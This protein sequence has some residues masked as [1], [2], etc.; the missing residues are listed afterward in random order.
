MRHGKR[1]KLTTS[2]I[3]NALKL[4]NV[5]VNGKLHSRTKMTMV[6]LSWQADLSNICVLCDSSPCMGFSRKSLSLFA[7]QAV[8]EESSIFMRKRKS[9]SVIL[10]T[11]RFPEF[12]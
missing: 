3:D 9:T 5:E 7:L 2:D 4:K 12:R 1:R 10:S 8:V 6:N 11:H